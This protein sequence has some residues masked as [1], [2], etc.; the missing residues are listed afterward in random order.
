MKKELI[1]NLQF[2]FRP[3]WWDMNGKFDKELDDFMNEL[4]DNH[5]FKESPW[6]EVALLGGVNIWIANHPYNSFMPE[7]LIWDKVRPSRLTILRGYN[8]LKSEVDL[9]KDRRKERR[10]NFYKLNN[11]PA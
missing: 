1:L 2:L 9:K 11:K 6:P 5:K 8:K 4:M 10:H 3:K 7:H